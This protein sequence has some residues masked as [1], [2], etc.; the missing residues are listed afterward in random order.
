MQPEKLEI[1]SSFES[2]TEDLSGNAILLK[3]GIR[4]FNED[5]K[6]G[7][8]YFVGKG[9]MENEPQSIASFLITHNEH[10]SK[11]QIGE[12]IAGKDNDDTQVLIHFTNLI[13][14]KKE[15]FDVS[16][17][18]Y[19][20]KFWL[21][22]EAQKIDRI[23][24]IFA[25]K[26][27]E[28]NPEVFPSADCVYVTTF[29]VIM[30]NTDMHSPVILEKDKMTKEGFIKN[31][32]GTWNDTDPPRKFLEELYDSISECEIVLKKGED[33][34]K[35]GWNKSVVALPH[36]K[37]QTRTWFCLYG[38]E[39]RWYRSLEQSSIMGRISLD[40]VTIREDVNIF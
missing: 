4:L 9:L 1:S 13:D 30:L 12:L 35:R 36:Y 27:F 22:G 31:N 39:L 14:F 21:P 25:N 37:V 2:D 40:Y 24:R 18:K 7:V 19:L 16:L 11:L 20:T 6:V 26:Y 28:D 38:N 8:A 23:T 32:S 10:L 17:R 15:K 33:P 5:W 3:N 29:S 34:E